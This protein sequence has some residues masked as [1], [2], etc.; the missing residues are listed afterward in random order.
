MWQF[1]WRSASA[2]AVAVLVATCWCRVTVAVG[3]S[4]RVAVVAV[5]VAVPVAVGTTVPVA[6]AVAVGVDVLVAVGVGEGAP[7]VPKAITLAEYAGKLY[8]KLVDKPDTGLVAT[9]AEPTPVSAALSCGMPYVYKV[10]VLPGVA[11]LTAMLA[12]R[13]LLA[14]L[15]TTKRQPSVSPLGR[16]HTK[17]RIVAPGAD[18]P[19]AAA[20]EVLQQP[21]DVKRRIG[22]SRAAGSTL[23]VMP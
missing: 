1:A 3:G 14:L 15:F 19:I 20:G 11:P 9:S 4:S 10:P 13:A 7:P 6:V 23:S 18:K 21:F 5:A 8:E 22:V 16:T 2:V 12:L 17:E